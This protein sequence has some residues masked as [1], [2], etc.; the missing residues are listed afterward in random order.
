MV[1]SPYGRKKISMIRK[2]IEDA[3]YPQIEE[4]IFEIARW[5]HDA[6]GKLSRI[7]NLLSTLTPDIYRITSRKQTGGHGSR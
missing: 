5:S 6:E 3:R 2:K 4:E 7:A 1:I